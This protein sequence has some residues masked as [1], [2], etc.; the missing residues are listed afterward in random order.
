M[1]VFR[2]TLN[3]PQAPP[4]SFVPK[5]NT[6]TLNIHTDDTVVM[7]EAGHMKILW[8]ISPS[9]IIKCSTILNKWIAKVLQKWMNMGV[10][11][12]TLTHLLFNL[13]ALPELSVGW[14]NQEIKEILQILHILPIGLIFSQT[15]Q[16]PPILPSTARVG[17]CKFL[18]KCRFLW[19]TLQP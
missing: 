18:K 12:S 7:Q 19:I 8:S 3:N 17:K 9:M 11:C 10:S 15:S 5:E 2:C 1:Q 6:K 14:L 16:L 4:S 13:Y